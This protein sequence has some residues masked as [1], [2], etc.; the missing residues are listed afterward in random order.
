M[1]PD[2]QINNIKIYVNIITLTNMLVSTYWEFASSETISTLTHHMNPKV[3]NKQKE[4]Q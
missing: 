4:K 3:D 1:A 2:V